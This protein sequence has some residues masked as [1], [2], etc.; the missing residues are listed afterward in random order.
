MSHVATIDL[1]IKDLDALAL[2][3]E[4]LGLELVRGQK[5]YNWY[6]RSVGDSPLPVGFTAQDLGKCDH[7]IRIKGTT[8]NG[9]IDNRMPYEIGLATRRDGKAGYTLMW[10]TWQGGHGL[11]HRVGGEKAEALKQ[12]YATEVAVRIAKREG[13][14]VVKREIRTDGSVAVVVQR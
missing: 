1:E 6:G 10:D 12:G 14:R 5:A 8:L 2:A 11:V 7:V 4:P 3:C 9:R 13:F